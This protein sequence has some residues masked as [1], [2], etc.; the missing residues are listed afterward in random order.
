MG[1]RTN[2]D[3]DFKGADEICDQA[4]RSGMLANVLFLLGG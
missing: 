4:G 2:E 3:P 1:A